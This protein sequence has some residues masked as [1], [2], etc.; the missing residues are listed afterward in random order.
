MSVE[1]APEKPGDAAAHDE[2]VALGREPARRRSVNAV[3]TLGGD[4]NVERENAPFG[5]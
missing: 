1:I 5:K 3:D 2:R 4:R